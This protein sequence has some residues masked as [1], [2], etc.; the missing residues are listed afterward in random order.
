MFGPT[1]LDIADHLNVG[2]GVLAADIALGPKTTP[3]YVV[4]HTLRTSE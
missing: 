2:V 3:L 4:C 1:L